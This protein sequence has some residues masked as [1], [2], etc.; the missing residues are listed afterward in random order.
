MRRVD[1]D[2]LRDLGARTFVGGLFVL[3]SMNLVNDFMRTG[4][5]TG[6]F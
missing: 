6:L 3:L 5:I 1:A 4:R 2:F